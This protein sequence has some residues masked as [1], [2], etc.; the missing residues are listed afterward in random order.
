MRKI[1]LDN[2]GTTGLDLRVIEAMQERGLTVHGAIYHLDSGKVEELYCAED[3]AAGTTR[4]D[5][6]LVN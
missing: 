4:A 1:Y 3:E 5:A 2:N 6:F